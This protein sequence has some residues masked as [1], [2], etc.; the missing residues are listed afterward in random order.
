MILV[1]ERCPEQRHDAVAHHLIDEAFVAVHRF[2]HALQHWG[3]NFARLLGVSVGKQ[4]GRTLHVGEQH[5]DLLALSLDGRTRLEDPLGQM[6]R[7]RRLRCVAALDDGPR[8][9]S[10]LRTKSGCRGKYGSAASA[11]VRERRGAVDA[12]PGKRWI[13]LLALGAVH[14]SELLLA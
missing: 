6:L 10:T 5:G 7:H 12:E 14:I 11:S 13:V 9:P 1:G 2:H 8:R 4:L 3:E